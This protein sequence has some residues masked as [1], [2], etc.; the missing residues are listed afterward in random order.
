M[1]G[2]GE[3]LDLAPISGREISPGKNTIRDK[4]GNAMQEVDGCGQDLSNCC[5]YF[6]GAFLRASTLEC[7]DP[8]LFHAGFSILSQ[9]DLLLKV[10]DLSSSVCWQGDPLSDRA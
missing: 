7:L 2:C 4:H 3:H 10:N 8:P 9:I 5:E 6:C 1:G